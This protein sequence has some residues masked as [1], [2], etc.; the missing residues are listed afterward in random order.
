MENNW[1]NK[2]PN[3]R[4]KEPIIKEGLDGQSGYNQKP[5]VYKPTRNPA[6]GNWPHSS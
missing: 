5:L 1:I 4:R 2:D 6:S 3:T